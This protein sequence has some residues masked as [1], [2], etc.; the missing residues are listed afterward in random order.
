MKVAILLDS[1]NLVFVTI[2]PKKGKKVTPEMLREVKAMLEPPRKSTCS[3][4]G[5]VSCSF[6]K[7]AH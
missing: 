7:D 2:K 1:G 5:Y 6:C 3:A 4:H